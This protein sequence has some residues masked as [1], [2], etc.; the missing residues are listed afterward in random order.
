MK[1]KHFFTIIMSIATLFFV[2]MLMVIFDYLLHLYLY[3]SYRLSNEVVTERKINEDR[4]YLKEAK[5]QGRELILFPYLYASNDNLKKFSSSLEILPINA[6]PNSDVY[7][8]NEGYGLITFKTDRMGFRNIDNVWDQLSDKKKKIIFIGDSFS[9]GACVEQNQ[10]IDSHFQDYLTYNLGLDGNSPNV[11][12]NLS[13]LFIPKIKPQFVIQLFFTNDFLE[14][15]DGIFKKNFLVKNLDKKYFKNSNKLELSDQIINTIDE[16]KRIINKTKI[17]LP[18]ERPNIFNRALRYITLPT[19]R[20]TFKVFYNNIFFKLSSQTKYSVDVLKEQCVKNEC[21]PI[22]GF[23]P[24]SQ[25]WEPNP[26]TD[27]FRR[28]IKKYTLEKDVKFIDFTEEIEAYGD[29]AYALKGSHMSPT[30]YKLIS[31]K[32]KI[33]LS[34]LN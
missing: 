22:I 20:N 27:N 31:E 10:T 21:I 34:N 23:I 33:N 30:G 2:F 3:K 16:A 5:N 9:Q 7:Y 6:Q 1:K 4:K 12:A 8:C 32:I 19:L 18:G 25:Y 11:Y 14:G 29:K 28:E 26:L 17:N 13:K 24:N 15:K